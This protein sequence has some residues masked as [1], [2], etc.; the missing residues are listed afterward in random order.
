MTPMMRQYL[1]IKEKYKDCLLFFR[2]GDFYE[3]FFD[4]AATA[5]RELDLTLTGRDCGLQERAPMCGVPFHAVDAYVSRLISTGYKVAI[6]EQ[7]ED[8]AL[9]KGLVERDVIRII[10]PGTVIEDQ[11][12]EKEENNYIASAFLTDRAAGLAYCDVSTGSFMVEEITEGDI[13]HALIDEITRVHPTEILVNEALYAASAFAKYVLPAYYVQK[14]SDSFYAYKSAYERLVRHFQVASLAGYGCESMPAAVSSAGALMSYLEETQRN[15]LSHIHR[16]SVVNNSTFMVLD[17]AT[18]RNL[19]LTM[20]L[21]NDGNRKNTLLYLLNDTCTSM[22]TRKLH[23]WIDRPLQSRDAISARQDSVEEFVRDVLLRAAVRDRLSAMSDIERLCSKIVYGTLNARDCNALASTLDAIPELKM[24]LSSCASEGVRRFLNETDD[25]NELKNTLHAAIID[26]PPAVIRD[27]GFIRPGYSQEIDELRSIRENSHQ[28]LQ[29][30]EQ[31][32]RNN[33]GIKK[34]RIG[35]N[36]VFGYYI[37]VTRSNYDQVPEHYIRKQTLANAERFITPELKEMEDTILGADEKILSLELKLFSELRETLL[38]F[39]EQLQKNAGLIA[40]IDC[41]QSLASVAADHGYTRPNITEDGVIHIRQ[42][43]HPIVENNSKER[44]IPNDVYLDDTDNR[45]LIITGPNMAGK[46]TYMRQVALITLM[47]HI[48]SFIPASFADICIV[49]RIF[50]RIGA[51]DDL[52]SGQSTFMV[53]MSEMANIINNATPKSL[54]I[55]DEIG[56]GTSTFDGLSIAWAILEH[57]ADKKKCGAKTLFATHYHE[58]TELEDKISGVV[59]YRISV[60]EVGEDILFLRKI[61]KGSGDKSFG[62]QVARL[63]G[64]PKEVLTRAKKILYDLESADI[65]RKQE[66]APAQSP[67][68]QPQFVQASLFDD[69]REAVLTRLLKQI[70]PDSMSPKEALDQLYVLKSVVSKGE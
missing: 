11:M 68:R 33:T 46:S 57:I 42:G 39:T 23:D 22:G 43:R 31:A 44:F 62:I 2:L 59:N 69:D 70:D 12:L 35:Y 51:S 50:T 6:C 27:G 58:L 3:M 47:A 60:K 52:A 7:R 10:T 4:D 24:L 49:D 25:L 56:R 37:E 48:G 29:D 41:F 65:N 8:P 28:W 21:R 67:S 17:S 30:F 1:E 20:P 26:D 64:L 40:E 32:E 34:L 54:L 66:N 55:L 16:I 14:Y 36:R 38:T 45:L 53:E 13:V 9:A 18:R 5:S 19:E 15:S 63:A 61:V